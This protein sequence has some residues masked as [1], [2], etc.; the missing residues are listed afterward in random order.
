MRAEARHQNFKISNQQLE[1]HFPLCQAA[2]RQNTLE[3]R[4]QAPV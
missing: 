4:W 3:L 2:Q 1:K